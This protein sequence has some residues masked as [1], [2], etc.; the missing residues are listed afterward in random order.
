MKFGARVNFRPGNAN[1]RA[2][3]GKSRDD[4]EAYI[5]YAAP[6]CVPACPVRTADRLRTGRQVIPRID[7]G[8]AEKGRLWMDTGSYDIFTYLV[9]QIRRRTVLIVIHFA[10]QPYEITINFI[11]Y[12]FG[13]LH[14]EFKKRHRISSSVPGKSIPCRCAQP[15]PGKCGTLPN[16]L[17]RTRFRLKTGNSGTITG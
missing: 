3:P 17:R 5:R 1:F 16:R 8:I 12:G 4:A 6:V 2:R 9:R 13:I 11:K 10:T 7:A 14:A 15:L